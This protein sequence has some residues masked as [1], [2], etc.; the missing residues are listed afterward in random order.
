MEFKDYYQVL[1]VSRDASQDEIK[2]A[3][4]K[5]AVKYHPDKNS[6]NRQA[7]EKFKEVNEANDVLSDPEKRKK[8]DQ[9]GSNWR[10]YEQSYGN[11]DF[12]QWA[13]QSGNQ[14]FQGQGFSEFS[15]DFSDFFNS[16]FSGNFAGDFG[17]GRSR[18][19]EAPRGEDYEAT[20]EISLQEAFEGTSRMIS[21]NGKNININVPRGVKSGQILRVR[22]KGGAPRRGGEAGNLLLNVQVADDPRFRRQGDDLYS[23]IEVPLYKAILGGDVTINTFRGTLSMK[24]PPETH[25]GKVFRMK[26][27]GMPVYQ[28]KDQFGDLYLTVVIDI[29]R[30]IT[31]METELFKKLSEMRR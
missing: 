5:L 16:F 12:S 19:R 1:G 21:I 23:E 29:P 3:Y 24:I 20:L 8:Y 25:R 17:S 2:K 7:E 10:Q 6:G 31:P 11:A 26:G 13:R 22:G 4:R 27:Q 14:G 30:N 18:R 28:K 15:G 9:L